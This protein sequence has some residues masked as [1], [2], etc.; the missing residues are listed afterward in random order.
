MF[1]CVSVES[2]YG[3]QRAFL[4]VRMEFYLINWENWADH[5]VLHSKMATEEI[6][7]VQTAGG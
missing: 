2:T 3:E 5:S 7:R 4:T 1:D 6:S